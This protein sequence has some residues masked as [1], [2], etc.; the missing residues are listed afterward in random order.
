MS[1]L[2]TNHSLI[3]YE[4]T[5]AK[6]W[7]G[8]VERARNGHF[9]FQRSY[10]DYHADRFE[11][12]SFL[13]LRGKTVVAVLPAHRVRNTLVSHGGLS[14][15]GWIQT[16][17]CLHHDIAAGFE[18]LGAE[19]RRRQLK[20]LLYTPSPYPYHT[21]PCG[22]DLY[23]L[24]KLGAHCVQVR[25]SAF[26]PL[27]P[28]PKR[29][30]EFRR[31][32]RK[33][34]ELAPGTIAETTDTE[35]FWECL[36]KFLAERHDAQPVHTAAEMRLL[37]ERFPDNIR[38]FVLH[39]DDEWRAGEVVFLSNNVLRFQYGFYFSKRHQGALSFRLQEWLREQE[40]IRRPWMDLG[41]SMNPETGDLIGHLH[42]HKENFG[43]RGVPIKTW[44]W[45]P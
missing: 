14:F 44:E 9:M 12:L 8:T 11:D 43:A 40:M 21:K 33:G 1:I 35:R 26:C 31:R 24:E 27:A 13:L 7:D 45:L 28:P 38:L 34:E 29:T 10:M 4:P 25:L 30:S 20:R 36:G 41:T 37:Q 15:G 18:L 42:L 6:V 5:W 19:M 32:L 17:R 23:L 22:D 16:P 39:H 2:Q 3:A